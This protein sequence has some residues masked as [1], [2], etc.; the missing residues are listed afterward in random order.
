MRSIS[1]SIPS[2]KIVSDLPTKT[3][4]FPK[5]IVDLE[6]AGHLPGSL[7]SYAFKSEI[8]YYA[9]LQASKF[10][11]TTKRAGWDC[12]RHYEIAANGAVP[13]FRNLT[14]KPA[15]CAPHGLNEDNCIIYHSYEDLINQLNN[16]NEQKYQDLQMS[17]LKWVKRNTTVE[18]AKKVLDTFLERKLTGK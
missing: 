16:L 10:G 5:H 4:L 1:F 15:T 12:L 9:D 13:C 8:E 2:E 11:I 18:L 7:T 17:A 6:V 3:K 14:Q